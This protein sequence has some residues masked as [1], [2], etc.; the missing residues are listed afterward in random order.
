MA[1]AVK[2]FADEYRSFPAWR[3]A[4]AWVLAEVG[5]EEEARQEL[6]RFAGN[7]IANVPRNHFWLASL[8]CLSEAAGTLADVPNAR[9]LYEILL[10]FARRGIVAPVAVYVG[11][12]SRSLGLL[13]TTLS[14]FHDSARHFD[15]A[16]ETNARMRA[17]P[18][19]AYTRYDY[20]H[21]LLRRDGSGDREK[22]A[23]LVAEALGTARTLGMTH[24]SEKA[25]VLE[26]QVEAPSRNRQAPAPSDS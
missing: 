23:A 18:W 4:L 16:L 14:R 5:R 1:D 21:M 9:M 13:A 10:P 6:D 20:A 19:L 24:L 12:V 8:W 26:S 25:A 3:C 2:A 17:I 7:G 11:S 22:A 15:E